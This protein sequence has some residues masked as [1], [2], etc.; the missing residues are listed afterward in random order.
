MKRIGIIGDK[1]SVL[2]FMAAGFAVFI[3]E[4]EKEAEDILKTAVKN[5]FSVLFITEALYQK[6]S[7]S[8]AKYKSSPELAV[9]P[10]PGK[11]GSMGI[12][13]SDIKSAVEKAVGAD[14]LK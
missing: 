11:G 10:L 9:L 7:E 2:C 3:T 1:E 6:L 14:I 12:G 13:L 8:I 5:D 4:D